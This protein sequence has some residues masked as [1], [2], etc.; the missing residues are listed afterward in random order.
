MTLREVPAQITHLVAEYNGEETSD[1]RRLEIEKVL[2]GLDETIDRKADA[3]ASIILGLEGAADIMKWEV[4][5]LTRL[6]KQR[7]GEAD[8]L[9]RYLG[10]CLQMLGLDKLDTRYHHFSFRLG[11]SVIVKDEAQIS[12]QYCIEI[13]A[14]LQPDKKLIKTALKSGFEI[15]GAWIDAKLHL[16][17][18]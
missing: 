2:D 11:E 15:D 17:I 10:N 9:R 16:Q 3:I 1:V 8:R 6:K 7:E 14:Q 13:P 4:D 18:R 12:A 5:R